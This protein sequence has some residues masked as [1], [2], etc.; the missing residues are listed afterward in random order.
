VTE[1]ATREQAIDHIEE[2]FEHN[3]AVDQQRKHPKA[4]SKPTAEQ[5]RQIQRSQVRIVETK[6]GRAALIG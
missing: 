5:A 6:L 2:A 3:Y 1:I 4:F